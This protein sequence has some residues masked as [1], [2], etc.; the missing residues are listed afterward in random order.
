MF[1][2][3]MRKA[4]IVKVIAEMVDNDV[5][6]EEMLEQVQVDTQELTPTKLKLQ[7]ARIAARVVIDKAQIEQETKFRELV[8]KERNNGA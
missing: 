7:K 4:N 5:F 2:R 3:V 6:E 8:L 1:M